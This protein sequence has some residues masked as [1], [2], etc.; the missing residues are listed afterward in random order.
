MAKGH[1]HLKRLKSEKSKVKLK[2]KTNQLPKNLNVTDTSFTAKKIVIQKQLKHHDD[3]EI[4]STRKLNIKELLMR[5]RHHNVTVRTEALREL[6]EILLIHPPKTLHSEL[7]SLIRGIASLSLDKEKN[8]RRNSTSALQLILEC[9]SK[10]QL[11]PYLDVLTSY[12]NCA[13]THINPHIKED[14]LHYL[15]V[16]V[17]NCGNMLM[18]DSHKI[19]SNFLGMICRLHGDIKR[20]GQLTTLPNSK[21]TSVR[22]RIQVLERLANMFKCILSDEEFDRTMRSSTIKREVRNYVRFIPIFSNSPAKTCEIDFNDDLNLITTTGRALSKIEFIQYVDTL[23]PLMFDIWLEVCPHE[24]LENYTEITI[25]SETAALLKS[26][27]RIIQSI[28]E[29]IDTLDHDDYDDDQDTKCWFIHKFHESYM[30]N[31]LSKFPYNKAGEFAN[32]SRKCQEDYS[33]MKSSESYLEQN[34][35]LC[36]IHIWCTSIISHKKFPDCVKKNCLSVIKYLND[37]IENWYINDSSV[38]L[39]LTK[40]L[41]TLFLTASSA[42]HVNGID[43]SRTLQLIVETSSDLPKNELQSDLSI[44]IGNIILECNLNELRREE[45]FKKYVATLPSLLLRPSIN[46]ATIRMISKIALCFKE[47]IREELTT[48]QEAIIENAKKINIIGSQ[49]DQT[50]RLMILNLFYFIDAELYY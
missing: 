20:S 31:F 46:E 33:G 26:I 12:L 45:A 3:T 11:I 15:D 8:V 49:D 7:G 25:S 41:R 40:L 44:I 32:K 5:L 4:L 36:R 19:L 47:W 37:N 42:W 13:M 6:K 50:S 38:L 30:K 34:L 39:Q 14:S 28:I 2:S 22:W 9:I 1:K 10:E 27:V 16:L 23:M 24:K 21:S 29:Y 48:K 17:H 18:K 35:G 43:L